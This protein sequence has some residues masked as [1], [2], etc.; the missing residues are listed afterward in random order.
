MFSSSVT[1]LF[2]SRAYKGRVSRCRDSEHVRGHR[3]V[4]GGARA[5]CDGKDDGNHFPLA[6]PPPAR[7]PLAPI[8]GVSW[9]LK[10]I[11]T[12]RKS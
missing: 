12:I 7:F 3:Y 10:N 1:Y 5:G 8:G 2:I 11:L 4:V 9:I 6:S